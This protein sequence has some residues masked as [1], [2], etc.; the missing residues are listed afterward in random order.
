MLIYDY[1]GGGIEKVVS[2]LIPMFI[3]H[4]HKVVLITDSIE[5]DK[6]FDIPKGSIRYVMNNKME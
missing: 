4:G 2:L 6:E 1:Y 5:K 3:K